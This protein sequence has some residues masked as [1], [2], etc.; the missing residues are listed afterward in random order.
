MEITLNIVFQG[1]Y[2]DSVALMRLSRDLAAMDGVNEAGLMMGSP[3]NKQI[4]KDAGLLADEGAA[5][6]GGD[7][8]LAIR[9]KNSASAQKAANEIEPRIKSQARSANGDSEWR[10][11]TIRAAA[12]A[13]P[14]AN[15]ALISVPGE[16]AAAE[17]RKAISRGLHVMMFSDNVSIED[18]ISLKIQAREKGVLMM[19]PDCG[20]AILDGMPLAFANQ[21]ER[22][23]IG[24]V[25]ASGT[26]IQ[27]VTSLIS[28]NGRGIS[29]AI[30]VGG[31]DLKNEIGG[32]STLMGIDRL[33]ADTATK[34]IV[35]I[36][37]PP[38]EKVLPK[39]MDRIAQSAK[40]FTVCFIGATDLDLPKNATAARTLKE[41]AQRALG[42][43][44]SKQSKAV[45][46]TVPENRKGIRGLYSGGTLA[47]ETQLI[48]LDAGLP[49]ASN[50]AV[51]GAVDLSAGA[52]AHQ[53]I[54]LGDDLYTQ[55]RPHPMIDP[56]I[57]REPL[58]EA[59]A[60]TTIGVILIDIV[61]GYGAHPDPA[62]QLVTMLSGLRRG[63]T[64]VVIASVTGTELD[65]QVR[66]SQIKA[67]EAADIHVAESNADAAL[68]ALRLL[69]V[70]S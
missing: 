13:N 36:S 17:A 46:I 52:T 22:G 26:G 40:P 1:F 49:V 19:G 57:R 58:A 63:N 30:G 42:G 18:E 20:T 44:D 2:K 23:D 4:L 12:K 32:V 66:S 59:M 7:L 11:Q 61:I 29:H 10:P 35:L 27:E 45:E 37:K 25:G 56:E 3:S 21:V 6:E 15:L 65:P 55:G 16:F 48:L 34:H 24:I 68:T 28:N 67:L 14:D 53:I 51:P 60:D 8:I 69:G 31:R 70:N 50:A 43:T 41:A 38:G 9:A 33:E 47:A 39:I 54:D 62:G 64:P 5:A